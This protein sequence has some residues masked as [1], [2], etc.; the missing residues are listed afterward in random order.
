M[1]G[2][3][4]ANILDIGSKLKTA[5]KVLTAYGVTHGPFAEAKEIAAGFM[6]IT[7]DDYEGSGTVVKTTP[8]MQMPGACVEI[9][10]MASF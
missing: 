8:T 6:I 9:R 1:E 3:F 5:G 10:D 7:A 2:K 4:N